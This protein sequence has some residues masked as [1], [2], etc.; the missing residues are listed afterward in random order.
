M[1]AVPVINRSDEK[2][3]NMAHLDLGLSRHRPARRAA[4]RA[5]G[6]AGVLFAV[7]ALARSRRALAE[8]DDHMLADIGVTREAAG[9][10]A[11]RPFWDA[12]DHWLR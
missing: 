8:L 11:A 7:L 1:I 9:R 3:L 4:R 5:G 2:E 6:I 10:E 12:P